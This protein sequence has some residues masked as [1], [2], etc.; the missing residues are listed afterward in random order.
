MP[1]ISTAAGIQNCISVRIAR[2]VWAVVIL[3]DMLSLPTRSLLQTLRYRSHPVRSLSRNGAV[4]LPYYDWTQGKRQVI[5]KLCEAYQLPRE[6]ELKAFVGANAAGPVALCVGV[7][8]GVAYAIDNVC[9]HARAPLAGGH[10]SEENVVCPLHGWQWN[11]VSGQPVHP[12]DPAIQT[13][14]MRQYGSEV[15]VRLP[16]TLPSTQN[17]TVEVEKSIARACSDLLR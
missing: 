7:V 14:E 6:G 1:P 4:A 13:Y 10:L 16:T 2:V 12:G 3:S 5:R 11:L 15:F 17:R 8:E 9:P